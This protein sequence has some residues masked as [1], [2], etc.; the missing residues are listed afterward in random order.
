MSR[1]WCDECGTHLSN[2]VHGAMARQ[3]GEMERIATALERIAD[4]LEA[5]REPTLE[6]FS[7]RPGLP[8]FDPG[9]IDEGTR[10]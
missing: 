6:L 10:P 7:E 3:E 1:A 2:C 8:P 4:V 9:L 5:D